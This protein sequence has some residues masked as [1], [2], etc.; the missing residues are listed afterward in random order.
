MRT[1]INLESKVLSVNNTFGIPTI[2]NRSYVMGMQCVG[3][4]EW[5]G[6]SSA[7]AE[8]M[9]T[10]EG[11]SIDKRVK[12]MRKEREDSSSFFPTI[13]SAIGYVLN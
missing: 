6:R 10:D 2:A 1:G 4:P 3:E 12:E 7:G 13:F 8:W 11:D 9:R 5:G